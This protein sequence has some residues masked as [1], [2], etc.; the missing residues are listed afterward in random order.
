[1]T[2]HKLDFSNKN[3]VSN[4]DV[5]NMQ[6]SYKYVVKLSTLQEHLNEQ[7]HLKNYHDFG[8]FDCIRKGCP[9]VS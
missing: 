3:I 9:I 4:D 8:R 6:I 1:M 7:S 2:L 5:N